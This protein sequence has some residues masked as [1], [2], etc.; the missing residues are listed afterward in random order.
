MAM[1]NIR[2]TQTR[3][4][5]APLTAV[6]ATA[7]THCRVGNLNTAAIFGASDNGAPSVLP[8]TRSLLDA[9]SAGRERHMGST[10]ER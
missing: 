5:H 4:H 3:S 9:K 1:G 7:L 10:G 8:D 2:F 6:R